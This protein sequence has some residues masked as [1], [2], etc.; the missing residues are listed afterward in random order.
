MLNRFCN[1]LLQLSYAVQG[2][3]IP[4][5]KALIMQLSLNCILFFIPTLRNNQE[6]PYSSICFKK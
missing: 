5:L 3:E 2:C 6:V 4:Q 1:K